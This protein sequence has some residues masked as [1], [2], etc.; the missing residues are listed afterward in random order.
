[1]NAKERFLQIA[2]FERKNDPMWWGIDAWIEAFRRWKREG[3]PVNSLK[4]KKEINM[5]LLGHQDQVEGLIPNASIVGMG[6]CNNPPWMPPLVPFYETKV[7]EDDSVHVIKIYHDGSKVKIMKN[8]PEAMPQYLE[9]PVK[10]RKTWNELK[11]RLEPH[12]NERFP[13]NWDIMTEKTVTQFS[14]K[15][16]LEG[17]SFED[18]DFVLSMRC[19]SLYGMPRDYMGLENISIALYDD[20]LLV[21]DM[22]EWQTYFSTEMIKKVFNAGISFEWALIWEDI[23]YNK[24]SLV[25]PN[26]VKKVMVPRY[27]EITELLRSGGVEVICVDCD[28][29][30]DELLPLWIEAG[31]NCIFPIERAAGNDPLKLRKKYGK[32]LIIVG[33][34]DKREISKGK[35]EI[36]GQVAM[37]KELI[38]YGGYF[39]NGDHHFPEDIS[40]ENIVYLINEVNNLTEY[41]ETRRTIKFNNG[42]R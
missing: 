8:N 21:E 23:A 9:Y 14:L 12:S 24:G 20:P 15:K 26:F 11:K 29:L 2:R 1:M 25:P 13:N 30:I 40:Y 31:I 35:S 42:K 37:V 36:D 27:R 7:L 16:E 39:V 17:K 33:G 32:N 10:D 34:I 4:N 6:P 19:A 5:H 18:R 38:K 28:G 41:P 22:I 3:M